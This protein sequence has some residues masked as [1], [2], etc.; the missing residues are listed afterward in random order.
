ML[1]VENDRDC[2][3]VGGGATTGQA[4]VMTHVRAPLTLG[5][6]SLRRLRY[7][8]P[9]APVAMVLAAGLGTR[10]RPFTEERPKPLVEVLGVPLVRWTLRSL[11]RAGVT[12]A[13]I[14]THHL[15]PAVEEALGASS[16][17]VELT[18]SYEPTILG[19]GGGVAQMAE[20]L[21]ESS[22]AALGTF[23]LLNADAL[24]DV[25]LAGMLA[26]HEARAP[27]A[28]L[29]LK[30][31]HDKEKFALIGT[32]DEDRIA[33]F[34][35]RN[36]IGRNPTVGDITRRRMFCGVHVIEPRLTERLPQGVFS[37]I[38]EIGYPPALDEGEVVRGFDV[39]GYFCDVGTPERLLD[40]SYRLLD[41]RETV[42]G[43]HLE[44]LPAE[45]RRFVAHSATVAADA[46][47][48]PPVLI[49]DG[50]VIGA[51]ARVGPHAV[52]GPGCRVGAGAVVERAVLQTGTEITA[53]ANVA[54]AICSQGHRV[55]AAVPTSGSAE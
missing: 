55:H 23:V 9:M 43:S 15:H 48:V 39:P 38:N 41:G 35:G 36:T 6:H 32:D 29:A 14:N 18:F 37:G 8:V 54:D 10:L 40:A 1:V 19:T 3:N 5:A 46:T 50:A 12:R 34:A 42:R 22:G 26:A 44:E 28:T 47:L 7:R 2:T 53:G 25:D 20:K 30:D 45:G 17:G 4:H 21:R 27:L 51:G 31:A 49:A 16:D 33:D 13:A 24:I 11:A 52:V